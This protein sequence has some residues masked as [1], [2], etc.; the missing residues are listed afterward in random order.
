[1][2]SGFF[3]DAYQAL[4]ITAKSYTALETMTNHALEQS[5]LG[6]SGQLFKTALLTIMIVVIFIGIIIAAIIKR[7]A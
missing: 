6:A 7:D 1:M 4:L 5:N 2:L 3:S